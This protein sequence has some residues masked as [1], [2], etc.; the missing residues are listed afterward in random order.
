LDV[1]HPRS[2]WQSR[3][4]STGAREIALTRGWEAG[5]S[6]SQQSDELA[7]LSGGQS[8]IDPAVALSEV[9]IVVV[10]TQHDIQRPRAS[11]ASTNSLPMP[12]TRPSI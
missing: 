3:N 5:D 7:K 8:S 4:Y 2:G 9:V 10:G 11:Q 12:R 6:K 1:G